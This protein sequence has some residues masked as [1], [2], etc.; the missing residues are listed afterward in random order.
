MI[1][2]TFQPNDCCSLSLEDVDLIWSIDFALGIKMKI[3]DYLPM[4]R[5][6]VADSVK[7]SG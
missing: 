1:F 3:F 4:S 2:A 6:R 5:R 7:N